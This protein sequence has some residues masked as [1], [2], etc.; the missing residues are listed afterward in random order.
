MI[1]VATD[2]EYEMAKK[3][4]KGEPIIKTGIGALNVAKALKD[5]PKNAHITNF[6]YA[7]SNNIPPES[8]VRI[9]KC[10]LYHPNVKYDEPEY[11]LNGETTCYK[12]CDFV[13][14]TDIKEPAA[15]DMELAF[16]LAQGFTN[17]ESIKIISDNLS[18]D[19]Y[20][21]KVNG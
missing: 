11:N 19:Q 7:G 1:V 17:V 8:E 12:S 15:F 14:E 16:I 21:E 9:G 5:C 6:G 13:T 10:R 4:F 3:R 18:L 2:Q 20:K